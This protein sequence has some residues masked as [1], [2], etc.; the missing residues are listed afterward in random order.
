MDSYYDELITVMLN[1][2]EYIIS[3]HVDTKRG[4]YYKEAKYNRHQY[5]NKKEI[6]LNL[7]LNKL[8]KVKDIYIIK[9]DM[10]QE[11]LSK[12]KKF[13]ENGEG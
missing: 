9:Q 1:N 6:V 3:V 10:I 8:Q 5:N 2:K 7:D 4:K 12:I 13:E 11:V